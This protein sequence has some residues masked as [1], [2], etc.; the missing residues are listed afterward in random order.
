VFAEAFTRAVEG[1][2]APRE[3]LVARLRYGLDGAPG[4]T[5]GQI[6]QTALRPGPAS[7]YVAP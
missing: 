3:R 7:C 6:G 4:R 2:D 5:S 1:L